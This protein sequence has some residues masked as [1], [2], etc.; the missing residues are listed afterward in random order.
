MVVYLGCI[1]RDKFGK[2]GWIN[3]HGYAAISEAETPGFWIILPLGAQIEQ[4]CH[5]NSCLHP[6]VQLQEHGI[7]WP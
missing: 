3:G 5:V 2:A 1:E 7:L 6:S 4:F